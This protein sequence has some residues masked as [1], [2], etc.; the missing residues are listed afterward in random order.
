MHCIVAKWA[1]PEEKG[2]FVAT[3]LG[4][5]LGTVVTFQLSGILTPI[6]GWRTVFYGEATVILI[7]TVLWVTLIANRPSEH[8]FIS[9]KE[10]KHIEQALGAS[11]SKKKVSESI[12]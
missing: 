1:P 5:N 6:I 8:N 11:V 7:V 2:K 9:D 12:C 3:L 4:G 10:L